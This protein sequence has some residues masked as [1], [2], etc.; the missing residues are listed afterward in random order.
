[1]TQKEFDL[2]QSVKLNK[3]GIMVE[4]GVAT[5]ID[6]HLKPNKQH[7]KVTLNRIDHLHIRSGRSKQSRVQRA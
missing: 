7:E 6:K 4:N 5:T 2:V 3:F 1:M